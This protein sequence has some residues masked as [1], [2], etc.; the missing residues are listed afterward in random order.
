MATVDL[1][2]LDIRL[3][4]DDDEKDTSGLK[5]ARE[6]KSLI[7]KIVLTGYPTPEL[8]REALTAVYG[9]PLAVGF[10]GK[11]EGPE[12]YSIRSSWPCSGEG[13]TSLLNSRP[14]ARSAYGCIPGKRSASRY[15][16]SI[17]PIR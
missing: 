2:I 15:G 9:E 16:A 12:N 6:A 10:V 4:D 14:L 7:P 8:A 17:V 3:R 5:V 11:A 13:N 1:A